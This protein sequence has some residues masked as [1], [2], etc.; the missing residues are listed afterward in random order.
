MIAR[1]G[2]IWI[3]GSNVKNTS[4][5]KSFLEDKKIQ[6]LI[7]ICKNISCTVF[8]HCL[9][10]YNLIEHIDVIALYC[11]SLFNKWIQSNHI[12]NGSQTQNWLLTYNVS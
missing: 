4:K 5:F 6:A 3:L 11:V 7:Q 1:H 8:L 2:T 10:K 12:S 9:F